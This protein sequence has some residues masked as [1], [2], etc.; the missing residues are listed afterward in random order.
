MNEKEIL[1]TGGTGRLGKELIKKFPESLHPSRSMMDIT[2][3]ESINKFINNKKISI[4]IH[5]AAMTDVKKCQNDHK[6]AWR[7]NVQ[8][9]QNL[10]KTCLRIIPK[11][12]FFYISTPCVFDGENAPYDEDSIPNPKN[13]YGFTKV[14][15][16]NI[17]T[18]LPN[19]HIIRTNFVSREKWPFPKAFVDR[20]GTYLYSDQVASIISENLDIFNQKILHIYGSQKISMYQLAK[21][22]NYG[23]EEMVMKDIDLPLTKDMSLISKHI[24]PYDLIKKE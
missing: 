18:I 19:S 11:V 5:A 3:E 16:E 14:I 6:E 13:Y 8:G 23:V 4:I 21:M 12:S 10:V 7:I 24:A 9:T 22:S 1:I 20:F 2:N 17:V 15:A